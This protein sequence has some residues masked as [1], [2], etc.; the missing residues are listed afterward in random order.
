M[1]PGTDLGRR[2]DTEFYD[3][4][5]PGCRRSAEATLDVIAGHLGAVAGSVSTVVDVGCGEGWWGRQFQDAGATVV[6][7]DGGTAPQAQIPVTVCDLTQPI[8]TTER[9]DLAICLEVAEHLPESAGAHLVAELVRL[10]DVVLFSAA[11][12]RQGGTG[13]VNCRPPAYWAARFASEGYG[14]DGSLRW[15]IWDLPEVEP[16]YKSNLLLFGRSIEVSKPLHVI[17]PDLWL[18]P[19]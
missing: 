3:I 2:Y 10:A 8:P 16:W 7:F 5:R 14:C 17:H 15:P 19:R 9:F 6:G 13:H 18:E 12:P 4:I 1:A 11:M